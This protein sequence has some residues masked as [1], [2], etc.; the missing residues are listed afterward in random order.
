[1][2]VSKDKAISVSYILGVDGE[3]VDQAEPTNPLEFI[4]GKGMLIKAFEKNIENMQIGDSFNFTIPCA[5]GYG[6]INKD[7]ILKLPKSTFEDGGGV[8]EGMLD[9]GS[10]VP[11]VDQEG[12]HYDALIL[13][14]TDD[15]VVLDFNHPLAGSDLHFTGKVEGIREATR[16]ELEHGHVHT[17]RHDGDCCGHCECN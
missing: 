7:Y 5:D 10:R 17:H 1:M 16:E 3:I 2:N 13:E 11:M 9:V 8:N 12:N 14:V 4:F 6:E 15:H